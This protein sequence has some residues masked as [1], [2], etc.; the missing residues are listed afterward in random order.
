MTNFKVIIQD[1]N[2]SEWSYCNANTFD[3]T[4]LN[5]NPLEK[6][7]FNNDIFIISKHEET[8]LIHS[9]IRNGSLI[10]GV[11]VLKDNKTYG[12]KNGRLLYKCIPDDTRIPSFLVPYEMKNMGFSKVFINLYVT[13]VFD[14]WSDKHPY[15]L[16][17]QVIGS[18]DML[19]NFYE[20]QLYCKSLHTSIQKFT[21]DTSK[22]LKTKSHDAFIE[23]IGI[24]YPSIENRTDKT[25]WNVFSIDGPTTVDFDDAFSIHSHENGIIQLSIYISN[26]TIWM[27]V[28]NLWD[29]FSQRISTIYLPDKKRPMLPTVLSDCLCSLQSGNTRIA[30]VMDIFI[31]NDYSILQIKYTNAMIKVSKNYIYEEVDLI[32]S[33]GYQHLF[34]VTKEMSKKYKYLNNVRNSNEMVSYLMILMNYHCSTEMLKHKNGIFRSSIIHS[35]DVCIPKELQVPDEVENFMKIWNSSIC[36]MYI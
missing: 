14:N 19:D 26:V 9:S 10:P 29:T 23:N 25:K 22:A 13:F 27:D 1:R 28:L 15:G 24:K 18:V 21:K 17:H 16:L 6:K 7:L 11:L 33:Y 34:S 32:K 2:Y 5:I 3:K 30:F 8:T 36:D 31:T 4:D 20:Y 35:K 12:R